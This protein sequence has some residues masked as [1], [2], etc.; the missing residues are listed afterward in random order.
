MPEGRPVADPK[1]MNGPVD[2][3]SYKSTSKERPVDEEA[4]ETDARRKT[5]R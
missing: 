1:P 5:G 4:Y 3:A 2:E